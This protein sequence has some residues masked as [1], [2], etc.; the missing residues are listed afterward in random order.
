MGGTEAV[1]DRLTARCSNPPG[2]SRNVR[3]RLAERE[4]GRECRLRSGATGRRP[5]GEVSRPT[6]CPCPFGLCSEPRH[7]AMQ[8]SQ[9]PHPPR[10]RMRHPDAP[11]TFA[12]G[13]PRPGPGRTRNPHNPTA[14][15][16]V[17]DPQTGNRRRVR[18][19]L[20]ASS[21]RSERR[22]ER[23]P[24]R[25]RRPA[26]TGR[27][28]GRLVAT[29]AGRPTKPRRGQESERRSGQSQRV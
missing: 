18:R 17:G 19:Y 22:E 20:A 13:E 23:L 27:T 12:S 29:L 24:V 14:E 10:C 4:R 8:P 9:S 21:A 1:G 28:G 11:A 3:T 16:R 15:L 2:T 26:T 5:R 6:A 7:T 25:S